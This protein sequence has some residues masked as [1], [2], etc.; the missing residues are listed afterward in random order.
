MNST[1]TAPRPPKLSLKDILFLPFGCLIQTP[2]LAVGL[3]LVIL[4]FGGIIFQSQNVDFWGLAS[5]NFDSFHIADNLKDVSGESDS[6]KISYEGA[7]IAKYTGVVRHVSPDRMADFPM[8]THD[9]L[10]TSGDFADPS[11]VVTTVQNHHFF[12]RSTS[13]DY[14][15]GKINLIHAVPETA[16]IYQQL[17]NIHKNDTVTITGKEI[18]KIDHLDKNGENKGW[19]QDQGC[20]TLLIQSVEISP[21]K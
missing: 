4:V 21:Q 2:L 1:E 7:G 10:V 8:L 9:I 11:L 17:L 6:W 15:K 20:N 12:W 16:E 3:L 18:L 5:P 13:R 19:W 14:P